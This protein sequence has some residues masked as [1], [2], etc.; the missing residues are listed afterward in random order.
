MGGLTDHRLGIYIHVQEQITQSV[1]VEL[2]IKL[3]TGERA[4]PWATGTKNVEAWECIRLGQDALNRYNA[5]DRIEAKRLFD[6]A[7]KL[8]PNYAMAWFSLGGY[9]FH[10]AESGIELPKQCRQKGEDQPCQ[11]HRSAG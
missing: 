6:R 9:H 10:V 5:E 1:V 7:L 2:Q 8:D 11:G 3:V 4:R